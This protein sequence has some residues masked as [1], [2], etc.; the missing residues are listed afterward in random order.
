[1]D[2]LEGLPKMEGPN[3]TPEHPGPSSEPKERKASRGQRN[4]GISAEPDIKGSSIEIR[5]V[6][7]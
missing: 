7:H 1:M 3:C 2:L 6:P 4:P 5:G